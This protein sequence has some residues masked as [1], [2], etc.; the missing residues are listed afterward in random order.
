MTDQPGLTFVADSPDLTFSYAEPGA[1]SERDALGLTRKSIVSHGACGV[2]W[3]QIG[4]QTG[5]CGG[6]H[7]TFSGLRSF[8]MHQRIKNGSV[9]CLAPES[10]G[11]EARR[12][13]NTPT[14]VWGR[15]SNRTGVNHRAAAVTSTIS[16]GQS[17]RHTEENL[18]G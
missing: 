14:L 7:L 8:D 1:E 5:H 13:R 4:N 16:P 18:N 3:T 17:D 15:P 11:L 9:V 6:C 10:V 2:K 12:D